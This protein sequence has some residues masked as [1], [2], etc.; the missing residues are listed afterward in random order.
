M[1]TP[2]ITY[3]YFL[4]DLIPILKDNLKEIKKDNID[5]YVKGQLFAYFDILTIIQQQAIA[6]GI[7]PDDIGIN[8]IKDA[9]FFP[10]K[11]LELVND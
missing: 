6:F 4:Q 3:K 10:N 9:D 1:K 2:L 7:N 8:D 5:D 11:R